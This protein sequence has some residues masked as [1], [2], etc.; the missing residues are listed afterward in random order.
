MFV[1]QIDQ[2]KRITVAMIHEDYVQRVEDYAKFKLP[3]GAS[4][5]ISY[6]AHQHAATCTEFKTRVNKAP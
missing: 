6:P 2:T 4:W 3:L 5:E 1:R